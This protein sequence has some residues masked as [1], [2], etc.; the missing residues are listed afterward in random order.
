MPWPVGERCATD[1]R[2]GARRA[3][4][5]VR[6]GSSSAE[7]LTKRGTRL[8]GECSERVLKK[9]ALQAAF[10]AKDEEQI[11]AVKE[12]IKEADEKWL[13]EM[14]DN[15]QQAARHDQRFL[16]EA[17][18]G[19]SRSQTKIYALKD[20]NNKLYDLTTWMRENEYRLFPTIHPDFLD[21]LSRIYDMDPAPPLLRRNKVLEPSAEA[22]F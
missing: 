4:L 8:P 21:A 16:S 5:S 2:S 7:A 12:Q 13:Q 9:Q 10:W 3:L 18:K 1:V 22:S 17:V 11:R 14:Q 20:E 15:F 19:E 6:R